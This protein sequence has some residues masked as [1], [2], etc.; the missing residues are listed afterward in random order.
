M[1]L[2]FNLFVQQ[3]A[4]GVSFKVSHSSSSRVRVRVRECS[5]E[6]VITIKAKVYKPETFALVD[7]PEV[8]RMQPCLV[9]EELSAR[10]QGEGTRVLLRNT[11]ARRRVFVIE[12]IVLTCGK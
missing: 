4:R 12:G 2:S 5:M 1:P 9:G 10:P 7:P 6:Q 3:R 11:T 8:M